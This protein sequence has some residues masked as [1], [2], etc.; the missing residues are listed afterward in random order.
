MAI[1]RDKAGVLTEEELRDVGILETYI[2]SVL[3]ARFDPH[4]GAGVGF[5]LEGLETVLRARHPSSTGV[6]ERVMREVCHRFREAGWQ[7]VVRNDSYYF[8]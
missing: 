6:S 8:R 5:Q 4:I 2:D 1:P 3:D 7:I